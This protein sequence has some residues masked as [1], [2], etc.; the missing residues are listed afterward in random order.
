MGDRVGAFMSELGLD[1]DYSHDVYGNVASMVMEGGDD[2]VVIDRCDGSDKAMAMI[3]VGVCD[4]VSKCCIKIG[5]ASRLTGL[6]HEQGPLIRHLSSKP[7][8]LGCLHGDSSRPFARG[9]IN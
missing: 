9:D 1:F 6:V 3:V 5:T 7:C 8:Q 4:A 2:V